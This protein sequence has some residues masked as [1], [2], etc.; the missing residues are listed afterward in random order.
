MEKTFFLITNC[1]YHFYFFGSFKASF[2]LIKDFQNKLKHDTNLFLRIKKVLYKNEK[3][4]VLKIFNKLFIFIINLLFSCCI[5][6][7]SIYITLVTMFAINCAFF[8]FCKSFSYFT[9]WLTCPVM[10]II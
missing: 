4:L 10:V 7:L 8:F 3:K 5:L 2:F 6:L 9:L 1:S